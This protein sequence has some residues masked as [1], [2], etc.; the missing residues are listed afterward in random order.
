MMYAPVG[1]CVVG[2]PEVCGSKGQ[3]IIQCG[4]ILIGGSVLSVGSESLR[5]VAPASMYSMPGTVLVGFGLCSM[6]S[7]FH[8]IATAS[9]HIAGSPTAVVLP[10]IQVQPLFP[11]RST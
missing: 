8:C 9:A 10:G 4:P 2:K 5:C 7:R 1:R 6:A 3:R 11:G